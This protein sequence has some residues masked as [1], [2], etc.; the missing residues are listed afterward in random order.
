M[1]S[2]RCPCVWFTSRCAQ[3]SLVPPRGSGRNLA[4][5]TAAPLGVHWQR[6]LQLSDGLRRASLAGYPFIESR[7]SGPSGGQISQVVSLLCLAG[8]SALCVT[9]DVYILIGDAL[10]RL[11]GRLVLSSGTV[12]TLSK[13]IDP[14]KVLDVS[15]TP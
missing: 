15:P 6:A 4:L 7:F 14:D 8:W 10:A 12:R 11:S 1:F 9:G 2:W 5:E 3:K 13:R